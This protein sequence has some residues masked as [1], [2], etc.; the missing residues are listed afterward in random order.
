MTHLIRTKKLLFAIAF[1]EKITISL[2]GWDAAQMNTIRVVDFSFMQQNLLL[3][4]L[5]GHFMTLH[6]VVR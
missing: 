1:N 5:P 2:V 6:F 3:N 4:Y